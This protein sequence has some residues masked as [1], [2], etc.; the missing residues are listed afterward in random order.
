MEGDNK[1]K[2]PEPSNKSGFVSSAV[3]NVAVN[4]RAD[5]SKNYDR[6]KGAIFINIDILLAIVDVVNKNYMKEVSYDEVD[7]VIIVCPS[8]E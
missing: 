6:D 1:H 3:S 8:Y 5:L 2:G 4:A 7:I